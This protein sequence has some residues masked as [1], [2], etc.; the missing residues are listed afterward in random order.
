MLSLEPGCASFR[1]FGKNGNRILSLIP[2]KRQVC[3]SVSQ[4]DF[5]GL[6]GWILSQNHVSMLKISQF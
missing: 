3:Q 1:G 6:N 2:G 5:A 4:G